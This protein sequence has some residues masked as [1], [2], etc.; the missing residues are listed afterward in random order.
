[1]KTDTLTTLE[2]HIAEKA[3]LMGIDGGEAKTKTGSKSGQQFEDDEQQPS[4]A[5]SPSTIS[6]KQRSSKDDGSPAMIHI[7][8]T[9]T[10]SAPHSTTSHVTTSSSSS[11]S[12]EGS[13]H[14]DKMDS[15]IK[16]S[17]ELTSPELQMDATQ[18][19]VKFTSDKKDDDESKRFALQCKSNSE[20]FYDASS[21]DTIGDLSRKFEKKEQVSKTISLPIL[22][23]KFE[24]LSKSSVDAEK[25]DDFSK[26]Y[27]YLQKIST[28]ESRSPTNLSD[29]SL[30]KQVERELQSKSVSLPV[31]KRPDDS[32]KYMTLPHLYKTTNLEDLTSKGATI[33]SAMTTSIIE[34]DDT[35]ADSTSETQA[36]AKQQAVK[37]V[38]E[39]TLDHEQRTFK[40]IRRATI[41]D[42][43]DLFEADVSGQGRVIHKT[44]T[45]V[46]RRTST[47]GPGE[48]VLE[49]ESL[50]D[51]GSDDEQPQSPR[52][53]VST[54]QFSRGR[55][56]SQ[57]YDSDDEMIESTFSASSNIGHFKE[58]DDIQ[59]QLASLQK[60]ASRR[61]SASM[62]Q[63]FYGSFPGSEDE[64]EQ[65]KKG[66]TQSVE[67]GDK[68]AEDEAKS[69]PVST[70]KTDEKKAEKEDPIRDWGSPMRLPEPRRNAQFLVWNPFREWGRP[71]GLPSP[72]PQRKD[73][74]GDI[75]INLTPI[76]AKGT[77]KRTSKKV[78]EKSTTGIRAIL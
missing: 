8:E 14:C 70:S 25:G 11:T 49:R 27:P 4:E 60:E 74:N 48:T 2:K 30:H 13:D 62:A 15:S 75:E 76:N 22:D 53:D 40:T 56:D 36:D 71:L 38:D 42:D 45:E 9:I 17:H 24:D 73:S 31:I 66:E 33:S 23:E 26:S 64:E 12:T 54:G 41:S 1:M 28:S 52:S 61:I 69:V 78:N 19:R 16:K 77:P 46:T 5:K 34:D 20:E 65:D 35:T 21:A 43:E 3:K 57:L 63:S 72:G 51:D 50:T 58:D 18:L 47:S 7:T 37:E 44:A 59:S 32:E 6:T 10:K 39:E 68:K 29:P 55:Q 67:S